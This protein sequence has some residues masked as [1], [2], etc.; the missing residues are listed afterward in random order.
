MELPPQFGEIAPK[1]VAAWIERQPTGSFFVQPQ[2]LARPSI[3]FFG[4]PFRCTFCK[5]RGKWET[6]ATTGAR[7]HHKRTNYYCPWAPLAGN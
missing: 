3:L 6:N 5:G 4:F 7:I 2:R 1:V